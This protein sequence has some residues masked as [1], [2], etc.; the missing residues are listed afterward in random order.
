MK[1]KCERTLVCLLDG[2]IIVHKTFQI[3]GS[4]VEG[5]THEEAVHKLEQA[6]KNKHVKMVVRR[7]KS[8][9]VLTFFLNV[10]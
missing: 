10:S 2:F 3:D 9:T 7:P 6:A 8:G 1:F 4:N 5:A